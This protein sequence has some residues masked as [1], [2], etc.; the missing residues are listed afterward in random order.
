M[1][2]AISSTVHSGTLGHYSGNVLLLKSAD[3]GRARYYGWPELTTGEVHSYLIPGTHVGILD[4][5]NVEILAKV[6]KQY[7]DDPDLFNQG[8]S[9]RL[10]P[11]SEARARSA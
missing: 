7:L 9:E 10:N 8:T 5:P 3:Q 1:V 2:A 6:L 4:K 11:F